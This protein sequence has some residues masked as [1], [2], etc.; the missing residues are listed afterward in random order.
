M[1]NYCNISKLCLL[2]FEV[3]KGSSCQGVNVYICM[4]NV[5]MH[6]YMYQKL[7][8]TYKK[9]KIIGLAHAFGKAVW[10]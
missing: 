1:N 9:Y 10:C 2:K 5:W 7:R 6:I 8:F 4:Y 3:I